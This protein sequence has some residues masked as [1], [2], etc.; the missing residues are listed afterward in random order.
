MAPLGAA[1]TGR[2]RPTRPA[3][4][5]AGSSRVVDLDQRVDRL[6]QALVVGF[7]LQVLTGA[8]THPLPVIGGRGAYGNR[9]LQGC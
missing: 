2:R 4:A 5:L 8:L 9:R 3:A 6:V 7:D 1:R